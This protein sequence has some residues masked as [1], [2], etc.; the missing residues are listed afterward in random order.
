LNSVALMYGDVLR[1]A[2]TGS[3]TWPLFQT[4]RIS[5]WQYITEDLYLFRFVQEMVQ[6][7]QL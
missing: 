3:D 7:S 5:M 6:S 1:R 4:Q 2:G